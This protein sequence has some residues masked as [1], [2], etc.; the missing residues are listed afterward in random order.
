MI[1]VFGTLLISCSGQE[2]HPALDS[3][4]GDAQNQPQDAS[5]TQPD[6]GL[7][8]TL[9]GR[10]FDSLQ[11]YVGTNAANDLLADSLSEVWC[12]G[13]TC[14]EQVAIYDDGT[15]VYQNIM[16]DVGSKGCVHL[17]TLTAAKVATLRES[18]TLWTA[19]TTPTVA[20][21][22]ECNQNDPTSADYAVDQYRGQQQPGFVRLLIGTSA[23]RGPTGSEE[24]KQQLDEFWAVAPREIDFVAF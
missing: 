9:D 14:Y 11:G 20:L 13:D 10:C 5:A 2:T 19:P 15:V 4:S 6:A 18:L 21:A 23:C 17:A 1:V 8:S 7:T 16:L 22:V 12:D 24:L 3:G